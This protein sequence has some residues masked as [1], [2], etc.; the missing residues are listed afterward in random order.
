[1][2]KILVML[3]LRI[4]GRTKKKEHNKQEDIGEE[5]G[6]ETV[7]E[8]GGAALTLGFFIFA[9]LAFTQDQARS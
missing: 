1:M 9:L 7:G 5:D 6:C 4:G 3:V 2:N 8:A